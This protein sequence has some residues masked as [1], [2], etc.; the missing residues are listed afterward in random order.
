VRL[1]S[2]EIVVTRSLASTSL[3]AS[4]RSETHSNVQ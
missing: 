4:T 1:P 2:V 3:A